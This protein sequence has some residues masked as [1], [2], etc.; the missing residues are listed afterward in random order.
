MSRSTDFIPFARPSVGEEE[1]QAV[2]SVLRSGWLTTAGEAQQFEREFAER[3]GTAYALAVNSATAG[4]HLSLEALGI[5]PG[6]SVLTTPY[7]FTAT[8][9]VA[10]YL[11]AEVRFADIEEESL[12]IDPREVERILSRSTKAKT[13][14]PD[15]LRS[16][17]GDRDAGKGL[18]RTGAGETSALLPVH[19]GGRPCKMNELA[20]ISEDYGI[21]VVEDAA[22]AF[23]VTWG[24]RYLGTIGKTGVYSFYATKTITTGEGGMVATDDEEVARRIRSMRLHGIDREVWNRYT[25]RGAHWSY[26]VVAPG[27]KY[28]LPD[29][30]A[31]VGRIQ[32][33][34]A[35]EFLRRRREIARRYREAFAELDFLRVPAEPEQTGT[36]M[37]TRP[38]PAHA[39]HLF[40]LRIVEERLDIG[41][42]RFIELL[43]ESGIGASV[44]YIPLH[45]MSYYKKTYGFRPEDFPVSLR[46]YRSAVSLPIYPALTE[47]QV[48][49]I[50]S[51]VRRIGEEHYRRMSR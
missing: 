7:T 36:A 20:E 44:H 21:P 33:R 12:T 8:A 5:G 27:Y 16:G 1:E 30:A 26:D 34:R 17:A 40:I 45:L 37:S 38:R 29:M 18:R 4:L 35:D 14:G 23:P 11:G 15:H 3:V 43:A 28:N 50:I 48:E 51:V 10:R 6:D 9:E 32:L 41:R 19:L 25:D 2:L 13:A 47:E 31:A 24:D 49:R 22:H 42:D 46:V 39:W